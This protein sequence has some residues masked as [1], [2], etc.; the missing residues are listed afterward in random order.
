MYKCNCNEW[1]CQPINLSHKIRNKEMH[2][3]YSST[4][5]LPFYLRS[6]FLLFHSM[7]NKFDSKMNFNDCYCYILL[8]FSVPFNVVCC[9]SAAFDWHE[10]APR[11][12]VK[13][14][15][16]TNYHTSWNTTTHK[17]RTEKTKYKIINWNRNMIKNMTTKSL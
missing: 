4:I 15:T 16:K 1:K 11:H 3:I 13:K 9:C 6:A 7:G 2:I 8:K 17:R 12:N 10:N 5:C 14:G